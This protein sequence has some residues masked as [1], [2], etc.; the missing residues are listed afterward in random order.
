VSAQARQ[1]SSQPAEAPKASTWLLC[2]TTDRA[3]EQIGFGAGA[4]RAVRGNQA[5]FGE[6][7]Q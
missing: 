7:S 3:D 6:E 5:F 2:A 4:P 1:R